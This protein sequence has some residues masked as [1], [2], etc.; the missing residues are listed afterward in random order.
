VPRAI[1]IGSVEYNCDFPTHCSLDKL[2]MHIGQMQDRA[3]VLPQDPAHRI[4]FAPSGGDRQRSAIRSEPR[5][6]NVL[7]PFDNPITDRF[8]LRFAAVLD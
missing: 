8:A 4:S 3:A 7:E 5:E 6:G 1:R 2:W